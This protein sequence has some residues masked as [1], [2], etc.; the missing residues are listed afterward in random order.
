[1]KLWIN[2]TDSI[3]NILGSGPIA[4]ATKFERARLL[5]RAGTFSFAMPAADPRAAL[6]QPKRIIHCYG[7]VNGAVTK[8]GAGIVDHIE[9]TPN[10]NGS[11]DISVSGDDLLRELTYRST[12]FVEIADS[13]SKATTRQADYVHRL[14]VYNERMDIYIEELALLQPDSFVYRKKALQIETLQNKIDQTASKLQEQTARLSGANSSITYYQDLI[15]TREIRLQIYKDELALLQ[16]DSLQYQR[17]LLSIKALQI[18]LDENKRRLAEQ[19]SRATQPG[20]DNIQNDPIEDPIMWLMEQAP[21]NWGVDLING[22][23]STETPV[24]A[25]FSGETILN[26]L[27]RLANH[28]GEHF[29]LGEGRQIVWIR[30]DYVSSGI[31]AIQGGHPI[32]LESN[33]DI[34]IIDKLSQSKDSYE[35]ISRIYPYGSGNGAI[36]VNLSNCTRTP[37]PGFTLN[38]EENY[39]KRDSTEATYGRIEKYLS[40]KEISPIDNSEDNVITAANILFDAALEHLLRN[41]EP[42]R[43]YSLSVRKVDRVI[44]PGETIRVIYRKVIDGYVAVD[45]DEELRVLEVKESYDSKGAG[46][47]GLTVSTVDRFPP[48]DADMVAQQMAQAKLMDSHPQLSLCLTTV[49]PYTRR[50]DATHPASFTVRIGG[51]VVDLRYAILRFRTDPLRSSTISLAG[52]GGTSTSSGSSSTAT[53][54]AGG[55]TN[56]SS[57]ASSN[58]TS[59]AGGAFNSTGDASSNATTSAGGGTNTSSGASSNTTTQAGG[60]FNSTGSASSTIT[61]TAGGGT[62]TSSGASSNTTTQAGGSF[63]STG[64]AST[65]FTTSAGGGTNTSSGA[66]STSVGGAARDVSTT[67]FAGY[68]RVSSPTSPTDTQTPKTQTDTGF[69]DVTLRT[70]PVTATQNLGSVSGTVPSKSFETGAW[71]DGLGNHTHNVS[72]TTSTVSVNLPTVTFPQQTVQGNLANHTHPFDHAHRG[73]LLNHAHDMPHT[74]NLT[75]Y[76]HTHDMQHTHPITIAAHAHDMSHTHTLTLYDHSHDMAHT[77]PITIAAHA[78]DMAH[79]HTLT[80]NDHSHNMAHTHSINIPAHSHDISHTHTLSIPA[81]SHDMAHTHSLTIAAHVH[82]INYGIYQDNRY[83]QQLQI[84]INGVNYTSLLGGPWAL[85]A[86]QAE[87]EVPIGE[88]LKAAGTLRQNHRVELRCGLGQGEV[89]VEVGMLLAVQAI[90]SY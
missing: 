86:A 43:A 70:S 71:G 66:S 68:Y 75:L 59:Q 27:I 61:T 49:G 5:D 23:D 88:I 60:S 19:Q 55:G 41:S 67:G 20:M 40:W 25:T 53:T 3:D 21:E 31:R 78:H 16:Q 73:G 37:P 13:R 17:K 4:S 8:L 82:N 79:T 22:Y 28:K 2:V 39:L 58:V 52:G 26:G 69:W 81:H 54:S 24:S 36:R 84:W 29:Y 38:K 85:S 34:A 12:A 32:A 74:H 89:E 18:G 48:T 65:V 64:S 1:M 7:M 15:N 62:N 57:G 51:E 10:P 56:T 14:N 77:H 44:N 76:D 35:L 46:V 47:V 11:V 30:N 87:G 83:P 9:L 63:N 90:I 72:I 6:L 50:V 42:Q 80:L 33:E 45:I